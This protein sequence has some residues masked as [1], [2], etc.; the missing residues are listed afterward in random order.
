M[1]RLYLDYGYY[2]HNR[3][4]LVCV[5]R[6]RVSGGCVVKQTSFGPRQGHFASLRRRKVSSCIT[7]GAWTTDDEHQS[8][9]SQAL[10]GIP[11]VRGGGGQLLK[12][13]VAYCGP[14]RPTAA[15]CSRLLLYRL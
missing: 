3:F 14:L 6:F 9:S 1:D 4:S 13:P 8:Q 2:G 15:R 10:A 11:N 7:L 12:Q 5:P